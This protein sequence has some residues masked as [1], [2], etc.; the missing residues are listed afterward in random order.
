ME[1]NQKEM[2]TDK[3]KWVEE[4]LSST[5]GIARAKSDILTDIVM[6]NITRPNRSKSEWVDEVMNSTEGISRAVTEDMTDSVLSRLGSPREYRILP[7]NDN[8]LVWKIAASVVF[9]LLLNGVSIYRY[10]SSISKVEK[11]HEIQ[12]AASELGMGQASSDAGTAI[13][14]N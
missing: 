6:A 2:Q 12:A 14:G 4:V 1:S 11:S 8:S 3:Q 9:L 7:T 5:D 13:F 10:Q